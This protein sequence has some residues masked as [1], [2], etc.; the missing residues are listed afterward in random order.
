MILPTFSLISE[1]FS[2]RACAALFPIDPI[3]RIYT[4]PMDIN[5]A[6]IILRLSKRTEYGLRSV[7]QLAR[8]WPTGFIQSRDLARQ[9]DLPNK[10]LEAILLAL[11]RGG[12]LESKVG[13]GGGYRLS[14]HP[15]DIAVGDLIRRLE[16]RLTIKEKEGVPSS[17][18]SPGKAAVRL[19]N[20]RLTQATDDVLDKMTLEQLM[21]Q[22]NRFAGNQQSMYYI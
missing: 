5:P 19:V 12:F 11:R 6:E 13:S 3:P 7:V 2:G 14:R 22:V 15:R 1:L 9:E 18:L 20:E 4:I 17:D 8:L 21:E 10:F 16:G